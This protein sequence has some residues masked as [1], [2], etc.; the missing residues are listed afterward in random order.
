MRKIKYIAVHCT[1]SS[2]RTT[3]IDTLMREFKRKGWKSPGYH[4]VVKVD[5]SI[6]QLLDVEK[7][8]NGV[9]IKGHSYNSESINVSY[10][11]GIDNEG[12]PIDNRTEEQKASLRK[13]LK[14]LKQ[15]YPDAIIQGHRDFSPDLNRDGKI[16]KN[17]WI[18]ACPCFDA[19]TEYADL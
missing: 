19:K 3:T 17:E 8:S 2:Q 4:Y 6:H 10:I 1:A 18:K 14:I 5:G 7:V 9:Y 16:S 12:N 13:L 15:K 11:G